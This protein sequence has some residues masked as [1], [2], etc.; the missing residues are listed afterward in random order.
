MNTP[1]NQLTPAQAERLALL[2]EELGEAQ[3]AIGKVLRHGYLSGNPDKLVNQGSAGITLTNR[4]EL[5]KELGDVKAAV[6]ILCNC[7]DLDSSNIHK[8]RVRKMQRVDR[9]LHHSTVYGE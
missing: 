8:A 2:A 9:Y 4:D 3:Q 7:G 5:E 1:F 6:A